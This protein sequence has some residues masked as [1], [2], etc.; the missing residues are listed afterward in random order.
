M[1]LDKIV[2]G[3]SYELIKTLPDKSVD[4]VV[5][6]PPYMIP[7]TTGG[8]ML[9]EKGIRGMFDDLESGTLTEGLRED[10]LDE[11][12][13]VMKKVNI[14]FW[15]NKLMIPQLIDYFVLKRGYKFDIIVWQKSNA[16]PLCGSKYLTDC[17]YCLYFHDTMTLNTTYD[18]A[19]TVYVQPINIKDKTDYSH[20]TIKPENIITNLII[21]SSNEGDVVLDPFMGSGTT[22]VCAKQLNRHFVGFEL[23]KKWVNVANDRLNGI[24]VK[25]RKMKDAGITDIFDFL[26]E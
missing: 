14:Y 3:D 13:R 23:E 10:M 7:H 21:N 22:A 20:P 17:E 24:T 4:L 12:M 6:D 9:I 25:E 19:K 18:T 11:L 2:C 15:C 16:M 1:V 5:T 8:G 26:G